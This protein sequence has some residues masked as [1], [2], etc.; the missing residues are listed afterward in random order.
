MPAVITE[1]APA[2][3]NLFLDVLNKRAD[4]FHNIRTIFQTVALHDTLHFK[5]SPN[6]ELH[7]HPQIDCPPAKNLAYKAALLFFQKIKQ[8]PA[9]SIAIEKRIP[10]AAGLAGGSSDAAACL[11]GLN[12][13]YQQPLTTS[14]LKVLARRLGAD[15][16]FLIEG[17]CAVGSAKGERLRPLANNLDCACLLLNPGWAAATVAGYQNLDLSLGRQMH[18]YRQCRLALQENNLARLHRYF[19]NIFEFAL[20]KQNAQLRKAKQNIIE[21]GFTPLLSGS[22]PSYFV[23]GVKDELKKLAT[24]LQKDWPFI[25]LSGFSF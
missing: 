5:K 22:G 3:I 18:S 25:K 12:R 20:L 1:K 9:V 19:F 14:Q 16:A 23:L 24:E 7:C 4:G 8:K 15:V 13:L 6:L 21:L 10:Q 2:K 17:G 11:R